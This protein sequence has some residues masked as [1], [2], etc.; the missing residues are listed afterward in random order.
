MTYNELIE[1]N[2]DLIKTQ[3]ECE[4][5]ADLYNKLSLLSRWWT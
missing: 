2:N 4:K 1:T 3:T 5:G